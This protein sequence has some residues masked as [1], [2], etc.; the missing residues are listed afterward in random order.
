MLIIGDSH[1]EALGPRLRRVRPDLGVTFNRG[2]TL[3]RTLDAGLVKGSPGELVALE[4]GTNEVFNGWPFSAYAAELDRAAKALDGCDVV[5]IGPPALERADLAR[6]V[7]DWDAMARLRA[8]ALGWRYVPSLDVTRGTWRHNGPGDS[9]IH[10]EDVGYDAWA[11]RIAQAIFPEPGG[12]ITQA[13]LLAVNPSMPD[14]RAAT[15]ARELQR[16]A[17][18]FGITTPADVAAFIAQVSEETDRFNTLVEYASGA[19]YEGSARLGN[20]QPGDGKRFKGRGAIQLTGRA[21]YVKA[22]LALGVDL[23][24]SPDLAAEPALAARIAAWFWR[25]HGLSALATGRRADFITTT[26]RINGGENGLSTRLMLW[27]RAKVRLGISDDWAA[28][29]TGAAGA[30][31][32]RLQRALIAAGQGMVS[33]DGVFGPLTEAAVRAYQKQHWLTADGIA[34]PKTLAALGVA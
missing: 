4:F 24:N 14:S 16:A 18:E 34:G 19:D 3:R 27:A 10:Q 9:G 33:T 23:V 25:E 17:D 11:R 30:K 21:N 26:H 32:V 28:L 1:V 20:T 29:Q 6:I 5:L 15:M 13:L 2:W 31:V 8:A 12:L 22:G 7:V